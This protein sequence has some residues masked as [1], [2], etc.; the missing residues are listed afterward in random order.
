MTPFAA[1]QCR[2]WT[3]AAGL[4]RYAWSPRWRVSTKRAPGTLLTPLGHTAG[5]RL[6]PLAAAGVTLNPV[7]LAGLA[8]PTTSFLPEISAQ[9][10]T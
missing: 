6:Y 2:G 5:V 9:P 8:K 3:T 1:A 4:G 7:V 10:Q